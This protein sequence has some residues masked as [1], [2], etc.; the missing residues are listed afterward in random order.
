MHMSGV[1]E[2]IAERVPDA[3]YVFPEGDAMLVLGSDERVRRS[4]RSG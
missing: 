3:V 2:R 1:D 4:E